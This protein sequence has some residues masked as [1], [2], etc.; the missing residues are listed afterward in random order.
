MRFE[1]TLSDNLR[2]AYKV[3]VTSEEISSAFKEIIEKKIKSKQYPGFRFGKA[4]FDYVAKKE[5]GI[6]DNVILDRVYK[7][8]EELKKK[9]KI[10]I[11]DLS[12]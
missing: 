7:S 1:Q 8:W 12:E 4:P 11:F 2:R 10:I 3:V 6:I 5:A 9:E